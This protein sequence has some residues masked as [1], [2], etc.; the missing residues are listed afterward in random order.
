M[1]MELQHLNAIRI[2]RGQ[3]VLRIGIGLNTG[4]VIAGNIG[5]NEK[6]EY[7]VIGDSVNLGSRIEAMTK[8]FG[9]DLLISKSVGD[10]LGGH[11]VLESAG[12]ATVKG[13]T[14]AVEV[15]RVTGYYDEAKKPVL[16]ETPYSSYQPDHGDKIYH[17]TAVA[18]APAKVAP[19]PVPT[20]TG[21]A[22]PLQPLEAA[23]PDPAHEPASGGAPPPKPKPAPAPAPVPAVPARAAM[24]ME[25]PLHA[26]PITEATPAPIAEATPAPIAEPTPAPIV[27]ATPA[28][29]EEATPPPIANPAPVA[30]AAPPEPAPSEV[31]PSEPAATDVSP[32][33]LAAAPFLDDRPPA[34]VP[35]PIEMGSPSHAPSQIVRLNEGD[36]N[37]PPSDKPDEMSTRFS[38]FMGNETP[39]SALAKPVASSSVKI[40]ELEVESEGAAPMLQTGTDAMEA[41]V[42]SDAASSDSGLAVKTA[43]PELTFESARDS[44]ESSYA[45]VS[46]PDAESGDRVEIQEPTE[47]LTIE[48]EAPPRPSTP[49]PPPGE[50]HPGPPVELSLPPVTDAAGGGYFGVE[51]DTNWYVRVGLETLGPFSSEELRGALARKEF[52]SDSMMASS[53][54]GPWKRIDGFPQFASKPKAA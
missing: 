25:T 38:Q 39:E 4:E 3:P 21:P 26:T 15:F 51:L 9:T 52:R 19:A 7:T 6:M 17:V 18:P 46:S 13:K 10:R 54:E 24:I 34:Q 8:E 2:Q 23:T 16:L 49:A 35:T 1:R 29:S 43:G 12:M 44:M 31:A 20:P 28:P 50:T 22:S 11:Y 36:D 32:F 41:L 47:N 42:K 53:P 45:G 48:M 33:S 37:A 30:A 14:D 5:S 40:D 27:E